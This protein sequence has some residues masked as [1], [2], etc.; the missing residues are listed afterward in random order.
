M[1][2]YDFENASPYS[3]AMSAVHNSTLKDAL[4]MAF[5]NA[6]CL[7]QTAKND[8]S[9]IQ[10]GLKMTD[11]QIVL[12]DDGELEA[13]R[14][15]VYPRECAQLLSNATYNVAEYTSLDDPLGALDPVRFNGTSVER[16]H[17]PG[18]TFYDDNR[19]RKPPNNSGANEDLNESSQID[20]S[21]IVYFRDGDIHSGEAS[22]REVEEGIEDG[23]LSARC[24][25]YVK[26]VGLWMSFESFIRSTKK[27][28]KSIL[29]SSQFDDH[30]QKGIHSDSME[31][32]SSPLLC[33]R[34]KES[35]DQPSVN[36]KAARDTCTWGHGELTV[37]G[38]SAEYDH[39]QIEH[40]LNVNWTRAEKDTQAKGFIIP[41]SKTKRIK[42][43]KPPSKLMRYVTQA[44]MQWDMLQ[45]GDR[46]LLGLSGG[47]DSLTLLHCLL[48]LQ[49][50]LPT[51]FEVEVC[52]IDPMTPSFDPS[53]LIPYIESLGLKYH[54]IRDDI[55]SRAS[56]SGRDGKVVSS[57]CAFCARMKR[58]NLYTCARQNNCNKLVLAQ[59]LDDC[60]ESLMMSIMHN[61][62][63]RTMKANYKINAGDISVIRP[64]VYCR[65]SLTTD[66]AKS[67]NLPVINENCPACFE[68]PKERARIKKML[69]REENLYPNFYDNIRRSLIP[70][71]HDDLTA[72]LHCYTEEA[73]AK[74]RKKIYPKG[75]KRDN[76]VDTG[77]I[78]K[79]EAEMT[80]E[81]GV[82]AHQLALSEASE[83]QLAIELARKKA[84]RYRLAGALATDARSQVPLIDK[85]C[86]AEGGCSLFD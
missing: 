30:Q 11:A 36:K 15:Y 55:V 40:S 59:H 71:M 64:L 86:T 3:C 63:L 9:A 34:K 5:R 33:L 65:E 62:F 19:K 45:D 13:L 58:G 73:V 81:L 23:E 51:K 85:V 24:E 12:G 70:L 44:V 2:H 7:L 4:D 72:I 53:P 6:D 75:N 39:H 84:N 21:E 20:F 8:Q 1:T 16:E 42:H 27:T 79:P 49:R 14:W 32:D 25:I 56:S 60:A 18:Q 46:L 31:I 61:G 29:G 41:S 54:Y 37:E 80:S 28:K 82:S 17:S 83:E 38:H 76:Y 43:V 77:I 26:D 57:L 22:L 74:S 47:K 69:S 35:I 78:G 50:K 68:E 48:E 52:T 66:F 67:S 10:Q